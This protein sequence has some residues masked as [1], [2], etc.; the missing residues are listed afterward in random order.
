MKALV[1]HRNHRIHRI[2]F[3]RFVRFVVENK[4]VEVYENEYCLECHPDGTRERSV[5]GLAKGIVLL[6]RTK[7][8]AV[9]TDAFI[10]RRSVIS[11]I[12][13]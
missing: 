2:L 7:V 13:V 12:S 5:V 11:V 9:A 1:S 10:P 6:W 8:L 4:I 3:V